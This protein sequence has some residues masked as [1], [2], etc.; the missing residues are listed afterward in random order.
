M[1]MRIRLRMHMRIR[2]P[3]RVTN[4][5]VELEPDRRIA[6]CHFARAVWRY[7][8]PPPTAARG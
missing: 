3:Y 8:L 6:W 1:H 5:V 7:D 2:L 4:R